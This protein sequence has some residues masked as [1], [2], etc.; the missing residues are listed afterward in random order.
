MSQSIT[1]QGVYKNNKKCVVG[2]HNP[3]NN[4]FFKQSEINHL[5]LMIATYLVPKSDKF[6]SLKVIMHSDGKEILNGE[7]DVKDLTLYRAEEFTNELIELYKF[8]NK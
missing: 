3:K 2:T 6:K 7:F 1:L 8:Y 4:R 5:S